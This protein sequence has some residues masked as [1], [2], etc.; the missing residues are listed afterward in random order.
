MMIYVL[1]VAPPEWTALV[2]WGDLWERVGDDEWR[3]GH[4]ATPKGDVCE[5]VHTYLELLMF[6]PVESVLTLA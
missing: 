6:G 5:H 3:W 1:R 2:Q 4:V